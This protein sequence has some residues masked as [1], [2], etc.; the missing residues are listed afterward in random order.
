I[1][2]DPRSQADPTRGTVTDDLVEAIDLLPTFVEALGGENESRSQW[3][4]GKSLMPIIHDQVAPERD[5]VVCEADWGF[6]EMAHHVTNV[7]GPRQQRATMIRNERYKYVLSEVGPN[8]LYD[9]QEDPDEQ[10]EKC[11]DPSVQSVVTDLHEQL[12]SWFR[13][14]RHDT[15]FSDE[16]M[17][18]T[19]EPGGTVRRG[20]PIGYWDEE[21]LAAGMRGELY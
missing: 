18:A 17:S 21:E 5:F 1:V 20:I 16:W 6:L 8:L 9:L 19:S 14:R 3:L 4:E 10:H 15:T 12:F 11:G 13:S 7:D 2:V